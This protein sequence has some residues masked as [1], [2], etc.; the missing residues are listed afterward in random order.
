MITDMTKKARLQTNRTG[1]YPINAGTFA[2]S[3]PGPREK[4]TQMN[5]IHI[6]HL[7]FFGTPVSTAFYHLSSFF[8]T[9]NP[10]MAVRQNS[11][12]IFVPAYF[13]NIRTPISVVSGQHNGN[14][15]TL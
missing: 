5:T 15:R 2:M 7:S 13:G 8:E 10:V 11:I 12:A 1:K 6:A 14:I 3:K 9:A 4:K